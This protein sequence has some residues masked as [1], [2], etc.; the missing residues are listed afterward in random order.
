MRR[1]SQCRYFWARRD[2]PAF[3]STMML[4]KYFTPMSTICPCFFDMAAHR[5]KF[6]FALVFMWVS[7]GFWHALGLQHSRS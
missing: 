6:T 3:M 5:Q 2:C 1:T 4:L 7:F